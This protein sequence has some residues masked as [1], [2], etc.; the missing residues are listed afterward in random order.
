[1][2]YPGGPS[3]EA[4][5][6]IAYSPQLKEEAP[7]SMGRAMGQSMGNS[8]AM[9][10]TQ[11]RAQEQSMGNSS[12]NG[13]SNG[14][15]KGMSAQ[16]SQAMA[17]Q[18]TSILGSIK[19]KLNSIDAK[20][21]S[22]PKSSSSGGLFGGSQK[23]GFLGLF[24]DKPNV[25]QINLPQ[26]NLPQ[27]NLP[28]ANLPQANL[29]QANLSQGNYVA[30]PMGRSTLPSAQNIVK[31]PAVTA[32]NTGSANERIRNLEQRLAAMESKGG[33]SFFGGRR[34]TRKTHKKRK[35]NKNKKSSRK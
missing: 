18:L 5:Q 4:S 35:V 20:V 15:S 30:Q 6:S 29:S 2:G 1:M 8:S 10:P 34:R 11:P 33:F 9:R 12:S 26:A 7:Q 27:A 16:S 21:S 3:G 17:Q 19:Q 28:Q 32:T 25:P 22:M 13:S 24:E 23:G 31:M 14:Y